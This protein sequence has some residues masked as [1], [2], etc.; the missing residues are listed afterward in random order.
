MEIYD[1]QGRHMVAFDTMLNTGPSDTGKLS[2]MLGGDIERTVY[3]FGKHY[4]FPA[5]P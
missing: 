2:L 3:D 1:G 4:T 5:T